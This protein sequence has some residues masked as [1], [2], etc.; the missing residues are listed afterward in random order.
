MIFITLWFHFTVTEAKEGGH[1]SWKKKCG[2]ETDRGKG[3]WR[4]KEKEKRREKRKK[5]RRRRREREEQSIVKR[6]GQ[7]LQG[8]VSTNV[9][10]SAHVHNMSVYIHMYIIKNICIPRHGIEAG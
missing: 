8:R 6:P 4:E 1:E 9:T 5:W 2:R 3:R 10:H 7:P